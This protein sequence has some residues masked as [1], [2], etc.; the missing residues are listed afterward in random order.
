MEEMLGKK[1]TCLMIC[2]KNWNGLMN[3]LVSTTFVSV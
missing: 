1:M 3:L 2:R